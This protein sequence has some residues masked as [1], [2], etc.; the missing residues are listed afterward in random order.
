M[1]SGLQSA[2]NGYNKFVGSFDRNAMSQAR[3]LNEMGVASTR[4]LDAPGEIEAAL[5]GDARQ[6]VPPE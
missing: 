1:R 4:S 2:V 6:G 5:R 3:K